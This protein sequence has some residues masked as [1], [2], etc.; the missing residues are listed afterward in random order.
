M[1]KASEEARFAYNHMDR[2]SAGTIV[3]H[4][5]ALCDEIEAGEK[6]VGELEAELDRCRDEYGELETM[7]HGYN[8]RA[9][10]L[11]AKATKLEAVA[12]AALYAYHYGYTREMVGD[13][14]RAAKML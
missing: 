7:C 1:S 4:I 3:Q 9:Q 10:E 14:L 5:P 11:D 6:R 8:D 13:A 2:Y 12:K